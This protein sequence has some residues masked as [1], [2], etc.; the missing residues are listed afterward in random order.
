MKERTLLILFLSLF[1]LPVEGYLYTPVGFS[2][3]KNALTIATHPGDILPH[4][5][6]IRH[7]GSPPATGSTEPGNLTDSVPCRVLADRVAP[8]GPMLSDR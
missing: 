6:L 8:G 2:L 5:R 4:S 3:D 1:T 7:S